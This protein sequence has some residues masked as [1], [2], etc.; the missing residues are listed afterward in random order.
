MSRKEELKAKLESKKPLPLNND[1]TGLDDINQLT[2][3]LP[4]ATGDNPLSTVALANPTVREQGELIFARGTLPDYDN[5]VALFQFISDDAE[6]DFYLIARLPDTWNFADSFDLPTIEQLSWSD[7]AGSNS[8]KPFLAQ[9]ALSQAF[10]V[11]SNQANPQKVNDFT[12]IPDLNIPPTFNDI[13]LQ[14]GLNFVS[15]LSLEGDQDFITYLKS[16]GVDTQTAVLSGQIDQNNPDSATA[17]DLVVSLPLAND[18]HE[19][20]VLNGKPLVSLI[21]PPQPSLHLTSP[22]RDLPPNRF[23]SGMDFTGHFSIGADEDIQLRVRLPLGPG[24]PLAFA[25]HL[26]KGIGLADL[27]NMGQLLDKEGV[28]QEQLAGLGTPP[29]LKDLA[30]TDFSLNITTPLESPSIS[31]LSIALQVGKRWPINDS[32]S[33]NDVGLRLGIATPLT[34]PASSIAIWGTMKLFEYNLLLSLQLPDLMVSAEL[35]PATPINLRTFLH[36]DLKLPFDRWPNV[37]IAAFAASFN[38]ASGEQFFSLGLAEWKIMSGLSMERVIL[39]LHRMNDTKT[40]VIDSVVTIA[41]VAISMLA[42]YSPEQQS[43]GLQFE[44]ST[45]PQAQLPLGHVID[46]LM[47]RLGLDIGLPDIL[48][49]LIVK[50]IA[51][52]YDGG[53]DFFSLSFTLQ[54]SDGSWEMIP[55]VL[56]MG[57]ATIRLEHIR[58]HLFLHIADTITFG[59]VPWQTS[60]TL[61]TL[62]GQ[63]VMPAG[64]TYPLGSLLSTF[65]LAGFGLDDLKLNNARLIFDG[66]NRMVS[67]HVEIEDAW[68][69]NFFKLKEVQIDIEYRGGAN[70]GTSGALWAG[71]EIGTGNRLTFAGVHPGPDQ[72]WQLRGEL[73]PTSPLTIRSVTDKFDI[74][75][76]VFPIPLDLGLTYLAVEYD[77]KSSRFIARCTLTLSDYAVLNLNI[78]RSH[79]TTPSL[80]ATTTGAES[81]PKE[82][83]NTFFSGQILVHDLE[84]DLIFSKNKSEISNN[85]ALIGLFRDSGGGVNVIEALMTALGGDDPPAGLAFKVKDALLIYEKDNIIKPAT[86]S[87]QVGKKSGAKL[88]FAMDTD[89]GLDL[90]GLGNL[91]LVGA[92]FAHSDTLKIAFTPIFSSGEFETDQISTLKSLLP[93]G[94]PQLP[95]TGVNGFSLVTSIQLGDKR[96]SLPLGMSGDDVKNNPDIGS[97]NLPDD[98]SKTPPAPPPLP[99]QNVKWIEIAKAFGPVVLKRIGIG[100]SGSEITVIL[101]GG[102]I[103]G[104]LK[105][106]LMGL[107]ASYNWSSHDL[108]FSLQGIGIDFQQGTLAFGADF[109]NMDGDFVGR[110]TLKMQKFSLSALGAFSTKGFPS[111]F[112]Y[113]FLNYPLGGPVFFFVE[114]LAAGFGFNRHLT[115]PDVGQIETFPLVQEAIKGDAPSPNLTGMTTGPKAV[116][117]GVQDELVRLH[118]YIYPAQGEYFLAVGLKF[119]SFKLIDTFALLTIAVNTHHFRFLINLI[120]VS[121]AKIPSESPKLLAVIQMAFKIQIDPQEGLISLQAQLTSNS[122]ILAPE[123]RLSGGFAYYAWFAGEH[124]GDFV[125]SLGGYHPHFDVPK[126]YPRVPRLRFHWDLPNAPV[127]IKGDAYYALTPI[128]LMAGGHLQASWHSGDLKAWFNIG[129]DFLIQWKP[130]HYEASAHLEIGASYTK[131]VLGITICISGSLGADLEIWGPDFAGRAH[132]K[133]GPIHFQVEFGNGSSP[134]PALTWP[135]FKKSFLPAK[136]LYSLTVTGGLIKEIKVKDKSYLVVNPKKFSLNATTIVPFTS[137]FIGEHLFEIKQFSSADLNKG[138]INTLGQDFEKNKHSLT[139]NAKIM[140]EQAGQQWGIVDGGKDYLIQLEDQTLRVYLK[141]GVEVPPQY[142]NFGVAPMDRKECIATQYF[143]SVRRDEEHDAHV[144]FEFKPIEKKF[145]AGLWGQGKQKAGGERLVSAIGGLHIEPHDPVAP[146]RTKPIERRNLDYQVYAGHRDVAV[147]PVIYKETSPADPA[148]T[149]KHS[150]GEAA[151]I[152]RRKGILASLDFD[153][154]QYGRLSPSLA[155]AFIGQPVIVE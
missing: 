138:Q 79:N 127:T 100:Y 89:I 28:I 1:V 74:E 12:N 81:K 101:D 60:V 71:L 139:A 70:G 102:L 48:S 13:E 34:D 49:D 16:L 36:E 37:N 94:A 57:A 153:P 93:P 29:A 123:C 86:P 126:H 23:L 26:D 15:T 85:T 45:A 91:P 107:G 119:N 133:F 77:T 105:I 106:A 22:L 140:V 40:L 9:L 115:I 137:Y 108:S 124:M 58:G 62:A 114:G 131:T 110:A 54:D 155:D 136:T 118:T 18:S 3:Q 75:T 43:S 50:D 52:S 121:T 141:H 88:L 64:Q 87:K 2:A 109:L 143:I 99:N 67:F 82:S 47:H 104:P 130:F 98:P 148:Q 149:V 24:E 44:G 51:F 8:F 150:L 147:P 76:D 7:E 14:P 152:E 33:F 32:L 25:T 134:P 96:L 151:V 65:H 120:G 117:S 80:P 125:N 27:K 103:I 39:S 142:K 53:S 55:G 68:D 69:L 5:V 63:A 92:A 154:D 35:D 31:Y 20:F 61:P 42:T 145:P 78:E 122:W 132:F 111:L 6:P 41:D 144:E 72:G 128:A 95:D 21:A 46:D 146:G 38:R 30:I 59:G 113:G 97:P 84:F 116:M 17:I 11:L 135:E 83:Y 129:V 90:S 4:P 10:F 56:E 19:L 112:I 66:S 73:T